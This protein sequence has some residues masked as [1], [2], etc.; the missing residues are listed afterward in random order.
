MM[1]PGTAHAHIRK[2]QISALVDNDNE[3][4]DRFDRVDP[5]QIAG[6]DYI[7]TI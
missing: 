6:L 2:R 3:L 7:R 5:D 1:P 4:Q